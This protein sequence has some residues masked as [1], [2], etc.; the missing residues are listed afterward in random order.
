MFSEGITPTWTPVSPRCRAQWFTIGIAV[1]RP[2]GR[3][4][5]NGRFAVWVPS[6]GPKLGA[7]YNVLAM[8]VSAGVAAPLASHGLYMGLVSASFAFIWFAKSG[9]T[10][11]YLTMALSAGVE[12]RLAS[13]SL[14][15]DWCQLLAH[16]SGLYLKMVMP[17]PDM[18]AFALFYMVSNHCN[19]D[20]E[21]IS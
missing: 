11:N 1:F 16:C 12:A 5:R 7:I 21:P 2:P 20:C 18:K 10:Y 8:A 4:L 13:H 19:G 17:L 9:T 3:L 14:Y 15:R 6:S